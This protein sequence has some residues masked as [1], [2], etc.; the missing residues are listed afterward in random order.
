MNVLVTLNLND[1]LTDN[2]RASLRHAAARWDAA[3]LELTAPWIDRCDAFGIKMAM[4]K[5][6]VSPHDRVAFFDADVL[7]RE[8]CPSPFD[9][10]PETHFGGVANFQGDTHGGDP[11]PTHFFWWGR[12]CNVLGT[13]P[14]YNPL[15]YING[16]LM[17]FRLDLHGPLWERG[18]R[19]FHN[20]PVVHP[21]DEQTALNVLLAAEQVPMTILVNDFC[22]LG[23]VPWTA[24]G[25]MQAYVYHLANLFPHRD[26][27]LKRRRLETVD[28]R[29]A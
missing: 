21:L 3:Y 10:V 20:A 24:E 16:G 5:L 9:A 4:H 14:T 22:R 8:D 2:S 23:A 7:V 29:I 15:T 6:P 28:W 26:P 27:V 1:Y 11:Y 18:Y 17:I 12:A 13:W 19:M 25:K